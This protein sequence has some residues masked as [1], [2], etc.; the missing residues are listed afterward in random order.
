[1]R[2]FASALAICVILSSFGLAAEQIR[3]T[4]SG[5]TFVNENMG[6]T[7]TFPDKFIAQPLDQLPQDPRTP[8]YILLALW[9]K[10]RRTPTPRVVFLYDIRRSRPNA[11]PDHIATYYLH[12]LVPGKDYKVS[13]PRKLTLAGNTMWRMDYWRPDDSG[14]SYNSAIVIPLRDGRILFIQMN[15]S[16]QSGLDS[17]VDS[18]REL[19]FKANSNATTLQKPQ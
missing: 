18:L 19:R 13:E 14:Q 1:M 6:L 7:Y 8:E 3:S 2:C 15:A 4:L 17:L 16:S 11:T 10:A 9:D 5:Q 12:S